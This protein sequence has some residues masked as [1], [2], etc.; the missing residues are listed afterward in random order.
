MRHRTIMRYSLRTRMR[1]C[2]ESYRSMTTGNVY[3]YCYLSWF[4]KIINRSFAIIWRTGYSNYQLQSDVFLRYLSRI[5]DIV[6]IGNK[7]VLF[8][9][10][11]TYV[12][13]VSV[14]EE[15]GWSTN[16]IKRLSAGSLVLISVPGTYNLHQSWRSHPILTRDHA[17]SPLR[18]RRHKKKKK[19]NAW[20]QANPVLA[21][22][23]WR[24]THLRLHSKW[25]ITTPVSLEK[26]FWPTTPYWSFQIFNY[27][28]SFI[29]ILNFKF[30]QDGPNH[31]IL[32]HLRNHGG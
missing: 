21:C 1:Y 7:N 12:W 14:E 23:T 5:T 27:L 16:Q 9:L 28:F 13:G 20:S 15:S 4:C 31:A 32:I 19:K 22:R 2:C 29:F 11:L 30:I 3:L 25:S 8:L 26:I 18:S 17:P 6:P 24:R 10:H